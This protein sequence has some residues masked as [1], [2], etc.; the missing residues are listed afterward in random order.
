MPTYEYTCT[1]CEHE[2]ELVRRMSEFQAPAS[3]PECQGEAQRAIRTAVSFNLPGD[4]W[5]SKNGR[6]KKQMAAKT[7]KFKAR[8]E[9][10][11]RDAPP[12]SL[13]PNVDGE[14]VGSW[15][16]AQKLAASKGKDARSYDKMVRKEQNK[17]KKVAS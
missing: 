12:V 3:C 4:G 2:F 9:E 1:A 16:E 17:D 10:Q 13:A 15:A 5:A 11:K 7:A 6:I 8:T 14:A